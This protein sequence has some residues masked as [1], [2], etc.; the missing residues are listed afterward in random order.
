MLFDSFYVSYLSEKNKGSK[1]PF[2]K[3][4]FIGFLSNC[5]GFFKKE[6]SSHLYLLQKPKK[7]K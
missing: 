6:H 1:I 7:A 3:G 4:I 2:I 5:V